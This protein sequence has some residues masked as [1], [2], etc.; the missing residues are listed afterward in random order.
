MRAYF[1][2]R[3]IIIKMVANVV[4]CCTII[5]QRLHL[6]L[7]I[8]KQLHT[9]MYSYLLCG[10]S[11]RSRI[12]P[13]GRSA[14]GCAYFVMY[15]WPWVFEI[16]FSD[17]VTKFCNRPESFQLHLRETYNRSNAVGHWAPK[18]WAAVKCTRFKQYS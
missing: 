2:E 12:W 1:V 5:L 4:K 14:S 6:R 15:Q 3:Q 8:E 16:L 18:I 13:G 9:H 11:G 17:P 10:A 7:I